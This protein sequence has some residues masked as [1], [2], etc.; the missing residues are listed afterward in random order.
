MELVDG[1]TEEK[2]A[3]SNFRMPIRAGILLAATGS[4][5]V[6]QS[7]SG[8]T[9]PV[10]VDNY[11]RAQSDVYFGL[12]VKNGALGQFRHGR[13]LAPIDRRGIIRPNSDTLY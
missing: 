5:A 3:M 2:E 11:N 8:S 6:A 4:V 9:V 7:P 10:T 1:L 13:E 12:S